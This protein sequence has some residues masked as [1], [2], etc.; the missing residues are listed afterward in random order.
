LWISHSAPI[1]VNGATVY[2]DNGP[3]IGGNAWSIH[4]GNNNV[5]N[6]T[7]TFI[8]DLPIGY[9]WQYTADTNV[10]PSNIS[11]A[12]NITYTLSNITTTNANGYYRVNAT[13]SQSGVI[14]VSSGWAQL[15]VL[16]SSTAQI[17]WSAKVPFTGLTAAQILGGTP[18]TP[19]ECESFGGV[20]LT[21]TNGTNLFIFDSTGASVS[22]VGG[23]ITWGPIP[24]QYNG[25]TGDT[26][27]D[28][29]LNN[30]YEGVNVMTVN[31]LISNNLYSVQLF[32]FGDSEAPARIGNFNTT[33]DTA[34]VSQSFAMGDNVYVVGT[35][36]A[37]N[38][39][40]QVNLTGG[41]TYM[42]CA[43]VRNVPPTPTISIVKVG[44]NLQVTY[45]NGILLQTTNL[46]NPLSWTTNSA[47]SPYTFA[48]S[49]TRMFFR[50]RTP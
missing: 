12:T 48:P 21:V 4:A 7:A 9:Q 36:T 20:S 43:I 10:A 17:H 28:T 45:A 16:P 25:T 22:Q 26:N 15:T 34:D 50:A 39:T 38:T 31:N 37:T 42:C 32:A 2:P 29:V 33:N 3:S 13:N 5:M 6:F 1:I 41:S 23:Y 46:A 44:S 47:T 11:N 40:Q 18:G 27:F 24:P 19:L 30:D 8:G 14:P 49:G 35:F